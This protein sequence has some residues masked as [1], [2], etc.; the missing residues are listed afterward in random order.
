MHFSIHNKIFI[1]D[2]NIYARIPCHLS[3]LFFAPSEQGHQVPFSPLLLNSTC[4]PYLGLRGAA[5]SQ[6]INL[7]FDTADSKKE[8]LPVIVLFQ[9]PPFQRTFP[10]RQSFLRTRCVLP[11]RDPGPIPSLNLLLSLLV[12]HLFGFAFVPYF[13]FFRWA[14]ISE[15]VLT[16]DL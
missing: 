4:V 9:R 2:F 1:S 16:R 12:L 8:R 13:L 7:L 11:K 6:G 5:V 10:V 15:W 14:L 3:C